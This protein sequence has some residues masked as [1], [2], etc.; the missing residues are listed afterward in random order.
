MRL[1]GRS[2]FLADG[3]LLWRAVRAARAARASKGVSAVAAALAI[4]LCAQASPEPT[5]NPPSK[6]NS[7]SPSASPAAG[8]AQANPSSSE[9]EKKP[10]TLSDKLAGLEFRNIGPFR[11]GRVT[12]VVGVPHQPLTFYF[13]GTGGGVWKTTDG[14]T[15]WDNVSDGF[16]RTRLGRRDR[17]RRLRSERRS[18]R[19]WAKAAS[20]ATSPPATASTSRRT[21]GKTWTHAGLTR[22]AAD[23]A[24]PR[25]S[26][27]TRTSST[28]RRSAT[29]RARTRSAASS[30]RRT[31]ARPGRRCSS[32]TTRRAPSTSSW[33]PR[34]PRVLYAALL[35]GAAQAR[36][37]SRAADPAAALYKTTDGGDT[38][39]KLDGRRAARRASWGASASRVSPARP[40]R[41]WAIVEA[42]DGGVFRSDDGGETWKKLNDE[43]EAAPARLVLH[44]HLRGPEERRHRLRA[45][46]RALPVRATA[47]RRSIPSACR[48]ATTT[49]CGSIPTTRS[50]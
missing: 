13:G 18:T 1:V 31:A 30:A 9:T 11:G 45:Q 42:E 41:V 25:P 47:A 26:R 17:G 5:P 8:R 21:R 44:A 12:A 16:F 19:G 2:L 7:S 27:R 6:K 20:A 33:I 36:G 23:R 46:R 48:T 28:S 38:W 39:K 22:D 10:L 29:L 15:S 50:A 4:A 37:A 34:N 40:E 14:G 3:S 32:S 43:N 49:T 24:R 35:A